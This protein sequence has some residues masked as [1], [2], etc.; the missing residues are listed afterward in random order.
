M[1][2]TGV[3]NRE[4]VD[5][6]DTLN[7]LEIFGF[8]DRNPKVKTCMRRPV[9]TPEEILSLDF[10]KVIALHRLSED[11]MVA[12]LL[13]VGLSR[14][15]IINVCSHPDLKNE[16]ERVR[17]AKMEEFK[18]E[19][20]ARQEEID[21]RIREAETDLAGISDGGHVQ[22]LFIDPDDI[23]RSTS[24]LKTIDFVVCVH[25]SLE[26][27]K[28]CLASILAARRQSDRL[29]IVDDGS[30]ADTQS[31]LQLFAAATARALL[32]RNDA[33]QGYTKAAN[34]GLRA[35][36]ADYIALVNSDAILPSH[37]AAKILAQ[38]EA[39]PDIGILGVMSNAASWQNV[40]ALLND[41]GAFAVNDLLPNH[42]IDEMD[43]LCAQFSAG[44]PT[45]VPLVNGFC[46]VVKAKVIEKIGYLDEIAFPEGFAEENDYCF[47]AWDAG[48]LCALA[49]DI[50]AYHAKSKSYGHERRIELSRRGK[51]RLEE[52]FSR[53]RIMRSVATM[54]K[55][56]V[57]QNMRERMSAYMQAPE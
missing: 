14:D 35:A 8:I 46:F 44:S 13:D 17:K 32:F 21:A 49:T 4:I 52:K 3:L 7:D 36:Q 33:A 38:G 28:E 27:V 18:Q 57:L 10:D 9:Y 50:Y 2:G 40:P 34:I 42:S 6:L 37:F 47:R 41:D 26:D 54:R 48:L 29:L 11:E 23:E 22:P 43:A 5:Y 53:H 30:D 24:H 16:R 20:Q 31:Y 55:H 19:L 15:R 51:E 45:I 39:H 12:R 25:N 56:P 1:Y